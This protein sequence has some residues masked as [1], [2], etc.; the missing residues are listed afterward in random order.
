M[1]GLFFLFA[2][3]AIGV[4]IVWTVIHGAAPGGG[5][6]IPEPRDPKRKLRRL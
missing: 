6:S 2:L 4:V 1:D 5:D 3:T